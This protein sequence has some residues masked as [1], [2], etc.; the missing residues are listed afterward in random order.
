MS[1]VAAA[2]KLQRQLR[3]H[4]NVI[5]SDGSSGKRG[6][7]DH[8]VEGW[9]IGRGGPPPTPTLFSVAGILW[10]IENGPDKVLRALLT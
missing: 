2:F 3:R 8:M 9:T 7:G 5:C 1:L 4:A 10:W 6:G